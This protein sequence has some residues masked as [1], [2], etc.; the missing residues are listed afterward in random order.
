[1]YSDKNLSVNLVRLKNRDTLIK[2]L[3]EVKLWKDYK[4]VNDRAIKAK[5]S[6]Y[7]DALITWLTK[8]N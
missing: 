1:M 6:E 5:V 7:L 2:Q 4:Y 8:E 3:N